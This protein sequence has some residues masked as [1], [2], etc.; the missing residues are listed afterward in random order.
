MSREGM[1]PFWTATMFALIAMVQL[2]V[3]HWHPQDSL[4]TQLPDLYWRRNWF[5]P[6]REV[7]EGVEV[8]MGQLE[9]Q[10]NPWH[11]PGGE[12]PSLPVGLI[13]PWVSSVCQWVS[14]VCFWM[15]ADGPPFQVHN[16]LGQG[17]SHH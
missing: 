10:L 16:P 11:G 14:S 3:P 5:S 7:G 1:E 8:E 15:H 9:E 6:S 2:V 13:S 4:A 12:G 17:W